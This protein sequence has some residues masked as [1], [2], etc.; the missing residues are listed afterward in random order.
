M[1]LAILSVMKFT[2]SHDHFSTTSRASDYETDGRRSHEVALNLHNTKSRDIASLIELPPLEKRF[3]RRKLAALASLYE[4]ASSSRVCTVQTEAEWGRW[5]PGRRQLY[6]LLLRGWHHV[7]PQG[8]E[9]G[10]QRKN[11]QTDE[12]CAV[13]PSVR[14]HTRWPSSPSRF[15]GSARWWK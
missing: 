3:S 6:N 15:A 9:A 1:I 12:G 13:E 7:Q 4:L 14:G 8:N 10:R 5:G 11:W 2:A